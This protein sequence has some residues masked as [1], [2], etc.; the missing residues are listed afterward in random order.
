MHLLPE[1][2]YMHTK[3]L[4][5]VCIVLEA[6]AWLKGHEIAKILWYLSENNIRVRW[7]QTHW[8][9]SPGYFVAES[10][11][12][13]SMHQLHFIFGHVPQL[14]HWSVILV[15]AHHFHLYSCHYRVMC[16]PSWKDLK[17]FIVQLLHSATCA[18][19]SFCMG[20]EK[21]KLRFPFYKVHL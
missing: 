3:W 16:F 19:N 9:Q 12:C 15:A 18:G 8:F 20:K 5:Y 7:G 2:L 14:F 10:D 17:P 11:I 1:L 4:L 21:F 13:L 6:D